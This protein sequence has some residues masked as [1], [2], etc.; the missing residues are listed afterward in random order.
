MRNDFA[1]NCFMIEREYRERRQKLLQ[2]FQHLFDTQKE[3][4]VGYDEMIIMSCFMLKWVV[5]CFAFI[6]DFKV[7]IDF[8][9]LFPLLTRLKTQKSN[10]PNETERVKCKTG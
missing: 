7:F 5:F 4:L 8:L 1:I 9:L 6:W 2:Q 3:E 10:R